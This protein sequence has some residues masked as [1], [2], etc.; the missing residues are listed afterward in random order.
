MALDG[1]FLTKVKDE[2]TKNAVGLRV[3]KVNQP[4]KDEIILS[5]RGKSGAFKLLCC[6]RADS[7]RIHFTSHNIDNPPTPP[8]FCMLMRKYLTGAL[9]KN[10]RQHEMDRI[11]FIDFDATN[12][13]GDRIELSLC[14]EIMGKYSNLI[15]IKDNRIVDSIKRVD[16]T[17]SSVRQILPGLEYQLPPQQYKLNIESTDTDTVI[18]KILSFSD[19]YLSSAIMNTIQGVSPIVAREIAYRCTF[20]DTMV[21]SLTDDEL[22]IL[23]AE[24]DFI[25]RGLHSL[26]EVYMVCQKDG[27]PKD[28]SHYFVRQYGDT[29]ATK[30]YES[31][32]ELLDDF[33]FERDRI[34]RINHRGHELIKLLNNLIERT[35]RKIALQKEEL[36]RCENKDQLRLFGELILANLYKLPKGVSF[37]EVENYYDNCEIIKIP[38]SPAHS[39]SENQKRYYKEYRKAQT[40]EKM[41]AE[42]I[43]QGEQEIIYLESVLDELS[44]ADTD[45][46]I[47]AI[48]LE[49]SQGGYIKN[50]KGKKQKPPKEL[51]PLEFCSDDGFKILVGRN[52]TQNDKLSLKTAAKNDMWLHTQKIPG[53]HVIIV[54]DGKEISDLSIEQAAVVAACYSKAAESSLVPVDYTKV[55]ALKKP[56]GAKAGMVIYHEYFTIIVNPDKELTKRLR[57]K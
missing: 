14:I 19:K 6:V 4:T 18:K 7:P 27:K 38:C 36:K 1:I 10:V 20:D 21:S 22:L 2:L 42:L 25:K 17:T 33:Y 43:L 29:L 55:K 9:I 12:E 28:I 30:A 52:N 57:V 13:I 5:L 51:P 8:M 56:N 50:T 53:S 35:V 40:A 45:S 39:P 16:F 46:E 34:N 11:L 37:Y 54:S 48:R 3:D 23:K 49:L 26:G 44:R 47:S 15:L 24:I 41:L 31:C 32:S